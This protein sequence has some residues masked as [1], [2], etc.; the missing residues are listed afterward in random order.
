MDA[1]V[2]VMQDTE[3]AALAARLEALERVIEGARNIAP[4]YS[5]F[6]DSDEQAAASRIGRLL[7]EITGETWALRKRV[8]LPST[9]ERAETACVPVEPPSIEDALALDAPA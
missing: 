4:F 7:Y 8:R 9:M 6:D 3:R 5:E 2:L 1:K